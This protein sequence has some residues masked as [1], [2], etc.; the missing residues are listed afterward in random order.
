[1]LSQLLLFPIFALAYA[2]VLFHR[3]IFETVLFQQEPLRRII[4]KSVNETRVHI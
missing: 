3:L 4:S 2:A 1:M